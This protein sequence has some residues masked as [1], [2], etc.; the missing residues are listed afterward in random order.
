M[1][2][3]VRVIVTAGYGTNCEMEM[4]NACRL[5]GAD[6]VDIVHLSDLL[7]GSVRLD[8]YHFLNLPAMANSEP[9]GLW[10]YSCVGSPVTG[11][12]Y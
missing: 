1:T 5:A 12:A 11:D 9:F 3:Q 2:S 7:D 4:A 10:G 6:H 8:D